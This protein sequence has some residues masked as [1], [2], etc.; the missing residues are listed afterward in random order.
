MMSTET[1][2][3]CKNSEKR[4]RKRLK[5][6]FISNVHIIYKATSTVSLRIKKSE[7]QN[8]YEADVLYFSLD[9]TF[10]L[11]LTFGRLIFV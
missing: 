2:G 10:A 1:K 6:D 11:I 9:L 7:G 5:Y 4:R 3:Q 8:N